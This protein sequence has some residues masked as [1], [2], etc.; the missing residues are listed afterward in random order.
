ML[1]GLHFSPAARNA[2]MVPQCLLVQRAVF[3]DNLSLCPLTKYGD[4]VQG[5]KYY[6]ISTLD[7]ESAVLSEA[8]RHP[9]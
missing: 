3:A 7:H 8:G 5:T 9:H 1:A 2:V 6:Q 4:V